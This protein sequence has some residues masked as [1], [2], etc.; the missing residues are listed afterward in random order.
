MILQ[1]NTC[2]FFLWVPL[3]KN[4]QCR[5]LQNIVGVW[6]RFKPQQIQGIGKKL[7][8]YSRLLDFASSFFCIRGEGG[9]G[10]ILDF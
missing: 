8:F 6:G 5:S 3:E 4:M 10:Q 9:G 2:F 1:K 7:L